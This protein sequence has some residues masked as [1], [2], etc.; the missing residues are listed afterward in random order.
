MQKSSV[1]SADTWVFQYLQNIRKYLNTHVS[2]SRWKLWP[3]KNSITLQTLQTSI[4][5][6]RKSQII[7]HQNNRDLFSCSRQKPTKYQA[8][9]GSALYLSSLYPQ[10]KLTSM[11]VDMPYSWRGDEYNALQKS[12]LG[13]KS[14]VLDKVT[15]RKIAEN[16]RHT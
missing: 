7:R 16:L 8:S 5:N 9:C 4:Q 10:G 13:K 15:Q 3:G 11:E 6:R 1:R 12:E 14:N 2:P